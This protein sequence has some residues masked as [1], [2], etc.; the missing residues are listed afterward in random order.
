[1]K[2]LFNVT[3][4]FFLIGLFWTALNEKSNKSAH[5]GLSESFVTLCCIWW[6]DFRWESEMK[7]NV[8]AIK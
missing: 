1:M 8:S 7:L 3:F 4:N 6:F 5:S 2:L